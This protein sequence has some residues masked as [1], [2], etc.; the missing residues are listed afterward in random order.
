MQLVISVSMFQPT[1]NIQQHECNCTN[2]S[3]RT[4]FSTPQV[5][6]TLA[7]VA[8]F[9]IA[10]MILYK[11]HALIAVYRI[12]TILTSNNSCV[13]CESSCVIFNVSN[14]TCSNCTKAN[15]FY[16][17][18]S[19]SCQIA[20]KLTCSTTHQALIV[21]VGV[22]T[23]SYFDYANNNCT[24]CSKSNQFNNTSTNSCTNCTSKYVLQY[25]Q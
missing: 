13:S 17:T 16:N 9:C 1:I 21:R 3:W 14:N 18:S 25:Y 15:Q 22:G 10:I 19:N 24:N 8:V 4:N 20:L 23:N 6:I 7:W 2:C 5:I 12:N 11:A